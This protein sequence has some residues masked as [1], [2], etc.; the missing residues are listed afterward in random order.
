VS[1]GSFCACS[2]PINLSSHVLE[3]NTSNGFGVLCGHVFIV[4]LSLTL[5]ILTHFKWSISF[6]SFWWD[7]SWNSGLHTHK[8]DALLE[9]HLQSIL[10]WLFWRWD[11]ANFLPMLALNH[12][13]PNLSIPSSYNYK[14]EPPEPSLTHLKQNLSNKCVLSF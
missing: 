11:L 3:R 6:F 10:H 7:C 13:P 14:H 4:L 5:G 9:P 8:A 2:S 1:E 12:Y